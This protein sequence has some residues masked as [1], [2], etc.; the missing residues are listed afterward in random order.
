M[1]GREGR[2]GGREGGKGGEGWMGGRGGREGGKGGMDG[3]EGRE[4]GREGLQQTMGPKVPVPLLLLA[5]KF[6]VTVK[7]RE[8][9]VTAITIEGEDFLLREG[10]APMK[11]CSCDCL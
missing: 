2:E 4:G 5:E 6:K 3:R 1:D 9:K 10:I 8:R 7:H 11:E